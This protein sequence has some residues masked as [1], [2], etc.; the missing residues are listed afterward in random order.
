MAQIA[1]YNMKAL[2]PAATIPSLGAGV[3]TA[4]FYFAPVGSNRIFLALTRQYQ[5]YRRCK[6]SVILDEKYENGDVPL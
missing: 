3:T 1:H 2:H 5:Y 6:A 4:F